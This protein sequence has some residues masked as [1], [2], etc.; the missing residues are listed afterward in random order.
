MQSLFFL[1][2]ELT[3]HLDCINITVINLIMVRKEIFFYFP[4]VQYRRDV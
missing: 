3:F 1:Q 2:N 4:I